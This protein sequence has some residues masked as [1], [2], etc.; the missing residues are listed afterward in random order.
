MN[1]PLIF[2]STFITTQSKVV[3]MRKAQK[4]YFKFRG[5]AYL[6][7]SKRLEREI[8]NEITRVEAILAEEER[9]NQ[10]SL[11]GDGFYTT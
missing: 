4:D 11:F 7:T 2:L 10:P 3:A 1:M 9:K 8:D 6:Q 5:S